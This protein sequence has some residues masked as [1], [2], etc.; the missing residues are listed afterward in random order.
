MGAPIGAIR[1]ALPASLE[2][3]VRMGLFE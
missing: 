1:R 2:W 3:M